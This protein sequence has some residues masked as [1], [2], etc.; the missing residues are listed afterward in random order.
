MKNKEIL[1]K[2][3]WWSEK[4]TNGIIVDSKGNE[5]YIDQS[6]LGPKQLSKIERGIFVLFYP[7]RCNDLLVAKSI[8]IPANNF[9]F[10]YEEK[11][12]AEENQLMLP[13]AG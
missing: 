12:K 8:K 2:I 5:F 6:V 7:N 10:K 4:D 3:L 9:I 13:F 11:F 1:G